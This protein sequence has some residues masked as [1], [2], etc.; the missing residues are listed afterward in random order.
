MA[1]LAEAGF[2]PRVRDRASRPFC[3]LVLERVFLATVADRL[4]AWLEREPPWR[5]V[6]TDFYEQHEFSLLDTE[7]PTPLA[8]LVEPAGLEVVR[9][10]IE[11]EFGCRLT[12]RVDLVAHKLLPGQRIAIHNDYLVGEDTHRLTIQLN[13]GLSDEDGG[14]FVLFNSFDPADIYR[15]FRPLNNTAI[16]FQISTKS[17]HAVSRLRGGERYTLVYSFHAH[18]PDP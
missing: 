13:R 1:K 2:A 7:L 4:L 12:D 10:F 11:E 16:A 8:H 14:F 15:I 3:H 9:S 17:H 6:E 18:N 5:L